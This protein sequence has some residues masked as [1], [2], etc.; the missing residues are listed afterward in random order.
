MKRRKRELKR[1]LGSSYSYKR[2]MSD[3][4]LKQLN[5][6][7]PK[8]FAENVVASLIAGCVKIEVVLFHG[9]CGLVLGYDVFV[10]DGVDSPEWIFFDSP[11]DE[12]ILKETT[13]LAVLDRVV[14]DNHLS[15]TECC[16]DTLDGKL[17]AS[18]K[19]K[20]TGK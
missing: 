15:Y 5:N 11:M 14:A 18:S 17:V 10:K 8:Y 20:S 16:F 13:L 7:I 12:V 19:K 1:L 3:R 4:E 2:Y 6:Q 9:S